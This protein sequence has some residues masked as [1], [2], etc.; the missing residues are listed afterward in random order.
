MKTID[1][2]KIHGDFYTDDAFGS[3]SWSSNGQYVTYV[4][5]NPP[6]VND[7]SALVEDWGEKFTGKGLPN[8]YLLD[9]ING[10]IQLIPV[11][12]N[13]IPAQPCISNDGNRLLIS[14]FE[15]TVPLHGV[16][17]CP[18]RPASI[19]CGHLNGTSWLRVSDPNVHARSARWF[20]SNSASGEIKEHIIWLQNRIG[21]PHNMCSELILHSEESIT[22]ITPIVY[23][24][25]NKE[26]F[27]GIFV[28]TLLLDPILSVE[29][30][31]NASWCILTSQWRSRKVCYIQFLRYRNVLFSAFLLLT[32]KLG[33]L[34][35]LLHWKNRD[36]GLF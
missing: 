9:I 34:Q 7:K 24:P 28:D 26:E 21:G 17:A 18:N 4:A 16:Y 20:A 2:S 31:N 10:T 23:K 5:A 30:T 12:E 8:V 15:H 22:T 13:I 25:A 14:G 19:W 27:P 11:P 1:V 33:I 36:V 3:L 29:V 32:S 6:N 35:T